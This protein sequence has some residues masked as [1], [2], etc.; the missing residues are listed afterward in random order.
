[1]KNHPKPLQNHFLK[2]VPA[3]LWLETLKA[4]TYNYLQPIVSPLKRFVKHLNHITINHLQTV[5]LKMKF[6]RFDFLVLDTVSHSVSLRLLRL[7]GLSVVACQP[8]AGSRTFGP[9]GR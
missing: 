8:L 9:D 6:L 4:L 5:S 1:M 7:K 2:P 3:S